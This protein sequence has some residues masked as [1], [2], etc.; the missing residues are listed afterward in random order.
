[1]KKYAMA[2]AGAVAMCVLLGFV[3]NALAADANQPKETPKEKVIGTVKE[4]KD[5]N[6][7]VTEVAVKSRRETYQI[8]LDAKGKELG[9]TMD[10]K[11]V[12]IVGTLE[13]KDGVKWLTVEK[14]SEE[15][16]PKHK[17]Q[18]AEKPSKNK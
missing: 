3:G 2:F 1:M 17:G 10:G 14:Y 16:G 8:K 7:V 9:K 13:V 12:R 15:P 18:P 4:V 11:R 5:S 6:G